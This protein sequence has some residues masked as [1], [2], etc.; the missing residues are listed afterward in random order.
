MMNSGHTAH[1]SVA[2]ANPAYTPAKIAKP[3]TS[4]GLRPMRSE[5]MPAGSDSAAYE[6]L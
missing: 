5:R 6:M 2:S 4:T 3:A 1:A